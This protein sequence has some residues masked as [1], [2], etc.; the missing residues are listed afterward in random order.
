MA[1]AK[2]QLAELKKRPNHNDVKRQF[3]ATAP[4]STTV[5]ADEVTS[6]ASSPSSGTP[7]ATCATLTRAAT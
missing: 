2:R 5:R 3:E 4:T 1:E 6:S 7:R